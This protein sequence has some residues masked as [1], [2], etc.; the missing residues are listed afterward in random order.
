MTGESVITSSPSTSTGTSGCPLTAIDRAAVV[1]GHVDP[2]DLEPLV[3][4]CQRDPLAVRGEWDPVDLHREG[5]IREPTAGAV[6]YTSAPQGP[7]V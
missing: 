1:G 6:R 2:F 5:T 3:G 7:F 4:E